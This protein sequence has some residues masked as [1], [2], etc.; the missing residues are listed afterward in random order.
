MSSYFEWSHAAWLQAEEDHPLERIALWGDRRRLH[1][2]LDPR[3]SMA[4]L[5]NGD[6]LTV[7]MQSPDGAFSEV[8]LRRGERGNG[9]AAWVVDRVAEISWPWPATPGWRLQ[10]SVGGRQLPEISSLL[11]EPFDVDGEG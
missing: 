1:L 11:L 2:M 4:E 8:E 7:R 9:V 5:I 3:G 6:A 10:V